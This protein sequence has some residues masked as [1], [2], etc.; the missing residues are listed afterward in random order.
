MKHIPLQMLVAMMA[1]ANTS[2]NVKFNKATPFNHP[3][4]G[5][6]HIEETLEEAR[7]KRNRRK[8]TR[9]NKFK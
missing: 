1:T 5:I 7:K 6:K 9:K 8:A 4:S 2:N 3:I